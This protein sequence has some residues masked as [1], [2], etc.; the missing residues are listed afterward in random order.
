MS[1]F[2]CYRLKCMH[3]YL[4][5]NPVDI[6]NTRVREERH[7]KDSILRCTPQEARALIGALQESLAWSAQDEDGDAGALVASEVV[8]NDR[9][10]YVRIKGHR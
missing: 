1:H 6:T 10:L 3:H 8:L 2:P 4:S 5:K 7:A 9:A